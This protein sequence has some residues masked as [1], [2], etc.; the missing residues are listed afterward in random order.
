VTINGILSPTHLLQSGPA[1]TAVPLV[2][3]YIYLPLLNK[4]V[5][6][7]FLVDSGADMTVLHPQD[8]LRLLPRIE[9]WQ[10]IDHY[11]TKTVG[12]AGHGLPHK[13]VDAVVVFKHHDNSLDSESLTLWIALPNPQNLLQESL[14]GRD[15]LG[16]FVTR[17]DRM[18]SFTLDR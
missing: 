15:V 4:G 9:D 3:A 1:L 10:A 7:Q 2:E 18:A 5:T 16:A 12:G 13:L 6:L 17:F 11:E 8:S 14:L